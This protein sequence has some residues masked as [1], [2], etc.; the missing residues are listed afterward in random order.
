M[1]DT[2]PPA[3]PVDVCDA[4]RACIHILSTKRCRRNNDHQLV[5]GHKDHACYSLVATLPAL[6]ADALDVEEERVRQASP[7]SSSTGGGGGAD[8]NED[9]DGGVGILLAT[10]FDLLLCPM[11][12]TEGGLNKRRNNGAVKSGQP[13]AWGQGVPMHASALCAWLDNIVS[14]RMLFSES[15][16]HRADDAMQRASGEDAVRRAAATLAHGFAWCTSTLP[17]D[18]MATRGTV[19]WMRMGDAV[20]EALRAH[21]TATRDWGVADLYVALGAWQQASSEGF[22]RCGL[23]AAFLDGTIEVR[24]DD[25]AYRNVPPQRLLSTSHV[26]RAA[27]YVAALVAAY[28]ILANEDH[29]V[30]RG[31]LRRRGASCSAALVLSARYA[32]IASMRAYELCGQYAGALHGFVFGGHGGVG[33]GDVSRRVCAQYARSCRAAIDHRL[34]DEL[35]GV[36][37][38]TAGLCAPHVDLSQLAA[39]TRAERERAAGAVNV[40]RPQHGYGIVPLGGR[41]AVELLARALA[42]GG[43]ASHPALA[44]RIVVL[45]EGVCLGDPPH[46]MRVD[47]VERRGGVRELPGCIRVGHDL[48]GLGPRGHLRLLTDLQPRAWERSMSDRLHLKLMR[49]SDALLTKECWKH[50]TSRRRKRMRGSDDRECAKDDDGSGSHD[51]QCATANARW[52]YSRLLCSVATSWLSHE[53]DAPP[54]P[55]GEATGELRYRR[56]LPSGPVDDAR[57]GRWLR[58]YF[59]VRALVEAWSVTTS[60]APM[61]T[62]LTLP[63]TPF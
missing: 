55:A 8:G 37:P 52:V 9:D 29:G 7:L 17:A 3:A 10:T 32:S 26:R 30:L 60:G 15:V 63:R 34:A 12:S 43:L 21:E 31:V 46:S 35:H 51:R 24:G 27:T 20:G 23:A 16:V 33:M 1:S 28:E 11:L 25:R 18:G 56:P 45:L 44:E 13:P 47:L 59:F 5:R 57:R 54:V 61:W 50:A 58:R 4:L 39:R 48:T 22:G 19:A 14:P 53:N 38:R 40:A 6:V 41:A 2:A 62:L 36:V 49:D 42:S